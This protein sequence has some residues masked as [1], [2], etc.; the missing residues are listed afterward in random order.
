MIKALRIKKCSDS[1][2]WYRGKVGQLVPLVQ[3]FD[4]CYMSLEPA[5]YKNIV[6]LEDA[7]IEEITDEQFNNPASYRNRANS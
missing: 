6:K 2:M 3:I 4:D 7:E 5:G 1:L